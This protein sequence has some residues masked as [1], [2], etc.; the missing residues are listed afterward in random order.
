MKYSV[1]RHSDGSLEIIAN[2]FSKSWKVKK[3]ILQEFDSLEAAEKY[4]ISI[5]NYLIISDGTEYVAIN[6]RKRMDSPDFSII[7]GVTTLNNAKKF[8]EQ[9]NKAPTNV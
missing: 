8:I 4:V 3:A 5:R 1:F 9:E 7:R 6:S 2:N